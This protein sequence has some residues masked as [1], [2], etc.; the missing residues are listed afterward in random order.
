MGRKLVNEFDDTLMTLVENLEPWNV[1]PWG[2]DILI[3]LYDQ[4]MDVVSKRKSEYLKGLHMSC[5]Y[6]LTYTLSG[7]LW[8]FKIWILESFER[9]NSWWSKDIEV[10]PR[11]LAWSKK[12]PRS[13]ISKLKDLVII[14]LNSC[15][16][17]LEAIIQVL[18]RKRSGGVV[19]KLKFNEDFFNLSAE[20]CNELNNVY[21]ELFKSPICSSGSGLLDVDI[22][23]DTDESVDS[24]VSSDNKLEDEIKEVVEKE[25]EEEKDDLKY[26]D[27]FST[28]EELG[29]HE[30]LLKNP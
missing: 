29:Y 11:G 28:M 12:V 18:V 9:S 22:D 8:S 2:E 15:I 6:V 26:F 30:W 20:F 14:D 19:D 1:F 3:H 16:F 17:K 27:I 7:F 10:I 25:E 24:L 21:L 13:K 23:E 4:I 5:N